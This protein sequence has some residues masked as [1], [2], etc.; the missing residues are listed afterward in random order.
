M[1]PLVRVLSRA[2]S[3]VYTLNPHSIRLHIPR[4]SPSQT[5]CSVGIRS[6][7]ERPWNRTAVGKSQSSD[8]GRPKVSLKLASAERCGA[9]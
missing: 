2:R 9:V 7:Q 3:H 8:T 6:H 1:S 4:E 5:S